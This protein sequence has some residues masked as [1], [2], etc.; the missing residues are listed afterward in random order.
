MDPTIVAVI[1]LALMAVLML[2]G[3]PIAFTM[4]AAGVLG[5]AYLLTPGA[6]THLLATNVWEQFS[7]YGL[8]VIPLFVLMGQFAYRAGTTERLYQA[9]YTWVG[10]MPGGLAA[11][12]IAASAGF[13][14]IC[15]SN[16]A[17]TATMGTIA[18]P[19]M[20]RYGYDPALSTGAIAV[21]GTL[22]VVIPPSVVL[23]V[24]AVQTEQSLLRLFVAAVI[25]GLIL[26]AL[27]LATIV[28]MCKRNPALGPLGPATSWGEKFRALTGVIEAL[29]L[30]SLV[31]GGLYMGWFTP[32][33]AGAAGAFGALAIGLIQR[34]LNLKGIVMSIIESVRISA[35]V[36][37]LIAGAVLFGRFLTVSRLPFELAEWAAALPVAP[38]VILLVVLGIY[39]IGGMLM[40]AL[41][42]LVV[43]IPIFFPLG[44]A[45][46]YDPVWYTV[47]LTIITTMGAVTPPVGVNVFIVHGLAPEVPIHTIFRG[48]MY[49]MVSYVVCI[50]L[51]WVFPVTV[52]GLPD[53]M[54]GPG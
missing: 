28:W 5:N 54:L 48:V 26:T 44:V 14:A 2:L 9:A 37:L 45:L 7:S 32:T 4:L 27:F 16:S 6:A 23:I 31:I 50:L 30:F 22:G 51:M 25:P 11:T 38:F 13:S 12:T 42:F 41:G 46:G 40:D 15:G 21:G 34:S 8:S 52:T 39:I 35:M 43:T 49:F 36:V 33:E 47:I 19:E 20:R 1:G 24:I 29:A 53:W 10:R 18:M 17:T 3:Q